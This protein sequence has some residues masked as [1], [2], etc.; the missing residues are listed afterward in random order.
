MSRSSRPPLSPLSSGSATY[1]SWSRRADNSLPRSPPPPPP[2]PPETASP[3]S[4]GN[5]LFPITSYH[6]YRFA[7]N[8]DRASIAFVSVSR[9]RGPSPPFAAGNVFTLKG[10][11]SGAVVVEGLRRTTLVYDELEFSVTTTSPPPPLLPRV[12]YATRTLLK[13]VSGTVLNPVSQSLYRP[14]TKA[15][16]KASRNY[17][18][19]LDRL[20]RERTQ[21][22]RRRPSFSSPV[23]GTLVDA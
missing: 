9:P 17:G 3:R 11:A 22:R 7:A 15:M 21:R 4:G 12:R 5:L 19:S 14:R 20:L 2:A 16:A 13:F 10:L 8:C 1:V 6:M 18:S 23:E